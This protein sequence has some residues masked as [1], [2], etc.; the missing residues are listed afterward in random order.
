LQIAHVLLDVFEIRLR[1][2]QV[3]LQPAEAEVYGG[4]GDVVGLLRRRDGLLD[5]LNLRLYRRD[6]LR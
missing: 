5:G 1:G 2:P 6:L 4:D 3:S